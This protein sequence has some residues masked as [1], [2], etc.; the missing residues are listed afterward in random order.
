MKP[1]YNE[2]SR[3]QMFLRCRQVPF[4]APNWR[5]DS[6]GCKGFPLKTGFHWAQVQFETYFS[7]I[8][9]FQGC[10]WGL[11]YS[12]YEKWCSRRGDFGGFT[13]SA[14]LREV[15]IIRAQQFAQYQHS[16]TF[17]PDHTTAARNL[18]SPETSV[19]AAGGGGGG[20]VDGQGHASTALPP[21]KRPVTEAAGA[22]V[23]LGRSG[24]VRKV[25]PTPTFDPRTF[26][27][28]ASRYSDCAIPYCCVILNFSWTL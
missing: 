5:L 15:E 2:I 14:I 1:A 25:S 3:H 12:V 9:C 10:Y 11:V 24:L 21:G 28:V 23:D 22:W 18:N 7:E 13:F 27:H 26:Q 4:H 17:L 8:C 20:G 6:R 19:P 16:N